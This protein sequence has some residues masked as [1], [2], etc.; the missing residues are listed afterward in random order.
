MPDRIKGALLTATG[1]ICWGLSGTMGQYLFS[2]EHMDSRWLVPIRLFLAGVL[3]LLY[4]A[5]KF[6]KEIFKPWTNRKDAFLLLLY[7][8]PGVALCQFLYFL[9]I[10]LSSAGVGTILQDVSPI[11]ILVTSCLLAK[12]KPHGYEII[13]IALGIGGVVLV[14]THGNL[15]ELAIPVTSLLAGC[16]SA[17]CIMI[18]NELGGPLLSKYSIVYIQGWSFCLGG[19][20]TGL[21]FQFWKIPYSPTG[22]GYVGIAFVVIVGNILAFTTY[23]TGVHLIGPESGILYGF[24]EPVTAAIIGCTLLGSSFTGWDALGFI[25]IFAMMVLISIGPKLQAKEKEKK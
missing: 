23:M 8:I 24:S 14:A 1:G 19:I 5:V 17:F 7:G 6:K 22:M 20:I 2:V 13:C 3:M 9:C 10:Q 15:T 4:G 18:Y 16:G 11:I 21:V 25:L 12:R